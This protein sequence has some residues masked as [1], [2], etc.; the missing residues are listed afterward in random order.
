MSMSYKSRR[1]WSLVILLVGL[2]IYIGAV[3]F[4][5]S[6][7]PRPPVLLE[8]ALYVFF[9]LAWA[10]PF[11]NVFKGVGKADPDADPN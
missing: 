7:I 11:K 9:G 6:L 1:R 3:W 2:P 8:L 5:L 4:I 10:L